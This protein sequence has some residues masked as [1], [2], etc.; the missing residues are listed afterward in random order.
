[1]SSS[2]P[3]FDGAE[4][5]PALLGFQIHHSSPWLPSTQGHTIQPRTVLSLTGLFY[6]CPEPW[7]RP[8]A[9]PRFH[10]SNLC[11]PTN[12]ISPL[13][14]SFA[15]IYCPS[16]Q[17]LTNTH[18]FPTDSQPGTQWRTQP[19]GIERTWGREAGGDLAKVSLQFLLC[20]VVGSSAKRWILNLFCNTGTH[21]YPPLCPGLCIYLLHAFQHSYVCERGYVCVYM[22]VHSPMYACK[23][24]HTYMGAFESLKSALDAVLQEPRSH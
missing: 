23:C 12:P 4:Q 13:F 19:A 9:H 10:S 8:Q 7:K 22:C 5:A 2:P 24:K 17:G 15:L 16:V 21:G 1:M 11:E 18:C 3:P 6:S 20:L 14:I